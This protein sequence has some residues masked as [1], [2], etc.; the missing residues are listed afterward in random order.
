M[1]KCTKC[2]DEYPATAKYFYRN[3][4]SIDGL[5]TYCKSCKSKM[6]KAYLAN[7]KVYERVLEKIYEWRAGKGREK[8]L[9]TRRAWDKSP[10]RVKWRRKKY[11]QKPRMFK[12]RDILEEE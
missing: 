4:Q 3:K 10:K 11:N 2:G 7:K 12:N 6:H 1:K 8:Y 5:H 9:A